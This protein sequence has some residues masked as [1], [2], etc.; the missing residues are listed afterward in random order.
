ML[1]LIQIYHH[2]LFV[3]DWGYGDGYGK[4]DH[5][6]FYENYIG[7]GWGSVRG[8]GQGSFGPRDKNIN[9]ALITGEGN[10]IGGNFNIYNN[11]D[12][13]FPVPFISDSSNMRVG[14]FVDLG[15]TYTTYNLGPVVSDN[16]QQ[17]TTPSF[18]NLK[19]SA[20]LQF[21]WASPVGPIAVSIADPF[22]VQKGDITQPFQFSIGQTF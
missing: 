5:L 19:Y 20:G 13:L 21:R 3:V 1:F 8:F 2:S 6:P 14:A 11:Y 12:V 22:N 16:P 15:N 7:G 4:T 18:G 17:Q 10:A 9:G